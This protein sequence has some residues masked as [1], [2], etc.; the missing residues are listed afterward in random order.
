MSLRA[1]CESDA[2]D[3][4]ALYKLAFGDAR[5]IDAEE[6]VSWFR[7]EAID[8]AHLRV[9]E[10]DGRVVGYGDVEVSEDDVALEV[11]APDHW[12]TFLGWAEEHGRTAEA[13]RVRVPCYSSGD[14]TAAAAGRGYRLWRSAYTMEVD[15]VGVAPTPPHDPLGLE[16]R[17]FRPS[18]D[19]AVRKT[20]NETFAEDPFFH[21]VTPAF[22]R[23]HFLGARGFDPS[24]WLLAWDGDELAGLV[25]AYPESV[26]EADLGWIGSLGVRVAW[27]RRGLGEALLRAAV[28]ELHGRGL[29]RVGLGVDTENETGALRLYERVGFRVVRRSDSW[30]LEL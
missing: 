19:E 23:E 16:L 6:I 7:S 18:D 28:A 30:A 14:L 26:G 27:R 3:V 11:A 21:A 17:T 29:R 10:V 24:L 5:P 12:A 2:E 20:V 22:F 13:R 1:L 15:L 4:A 9:L 8:P 25:L